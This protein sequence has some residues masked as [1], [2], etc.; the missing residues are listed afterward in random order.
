[1]EIESPEKETRYTA[2]ANLPRKLKIYGGKIKV[3][4]TR[5]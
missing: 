5:M 4:K 1:M 3:L 2:I